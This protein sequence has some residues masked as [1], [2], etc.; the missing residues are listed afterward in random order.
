MTTQDLMTM[1][2]NHPKGLVAQVHVRSQ[3]SVGAGGPGQ[4][5]GPDTYVAVTVSPH[6]VDVPYTLRADVLAKRGIALV[7]FGEGYA[8]HQGPRSALGQELESARVFAESVNNA[9]VM[10]PSEE[11]AADYAYTRMAR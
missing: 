2:A 9:P 6:G 8:A 3:K 11:A 4:F 1:R 10:L 5:G 7:Y